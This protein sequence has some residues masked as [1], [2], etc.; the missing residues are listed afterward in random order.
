[1]A[2]AVF[3]SVELRGVSFGFQARVY[4]LVRNMAREEGFGRNVIVGGDSVEEDVVSDDGTEVS[5]SFGTC[6]PI[7]VVDSDVESVINLVDDDDDIARPSVDGE[8]GGAVNDTCKEGGDVEDG[9][10]E[11]A[12]FQVFNE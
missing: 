10:D 8:D 7:V 2:G 12:Q 1:M 4:E 11:V 5:P 3:G 9:G 6:P